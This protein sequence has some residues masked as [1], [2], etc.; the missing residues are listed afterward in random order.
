MKLNAISEKMLEALRCFLNGEK[1]MWEDGLSAEDWTELFRLCQH[2]QIL[3]MIY[4]TVYACPAFAS[5]PPDLV[6]M[7][8]GQVI[9]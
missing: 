8:K 9:R 4:D 7:I 3:P 6:Q 1:V 5:C 2:H